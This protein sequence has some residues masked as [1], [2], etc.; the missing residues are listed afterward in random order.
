M[1]DERYTSA[2]GAELLAAASARRELLASIVTVAGG[3]FRAQAASIALHD[4]NTN[5]LVFEAVWG[6]GEDELVGSRFAAD[7][8][9]AGAVLQSEEPLVLDD[10]A[11]DPRFARRVAEGSGY[12]P[13]A[14]MAAPLL[15]GERA[16]GVLSV[17]D[18]GDT[19]RSTLEE[20]GLLATFAGQAAIAVDLIAAARRARDLVD[21]GHDDIAIVARLAARLDA[22]PDERRAAGLRLLSALEALLTD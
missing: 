15:R 13:A 2:I 3:I 1:T 4:T 14:L 12:V 16:L 10:V 22:V 18:R 6:Q 5:E 11:R 21:S 20:V 19:G 8:G 17:L 7:A 9:I